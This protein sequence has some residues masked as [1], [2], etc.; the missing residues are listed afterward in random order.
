MI[1]EDER[2]QRVARVLS[3]MTRDELEVVASLV[4][5][6]VD[7]LVELAKPPVRPDGSLGRYVCPPIEGA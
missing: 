1:N 3:Q 7:T 5:C 4:G 2:R 6:A